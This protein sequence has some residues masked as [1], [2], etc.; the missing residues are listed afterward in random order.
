MSNYF[1]CFAN[2]IFFISDKFYTFFTKHLFWVYRFYS[3]V[4]KWVSTVDKVDNFV[5]NPIL[6]HFYPFFKR[7][8]QPKETAIQPPPAENKSP[9]SLDGKGKGGFSTVSTAPIITSVFIYYIIYSIY[10][11][12][13]GRTESVTL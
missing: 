4:K 13:N 8:F 1:F 3:P 2:S 12:L 10:C 9:A 7:A 6:V 11:V 5:H